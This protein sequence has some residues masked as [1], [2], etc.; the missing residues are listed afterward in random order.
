MVC[1]QITLRICFSQQLKTFLGFRLSQNFANIIRIIGCIEFIW[2]P[3]LTTNTFATTNSSRKIAKST[4]EW[5]FLSDFCEFSRFLYLYISKRV[6]TA[7]GGGPLKLPYGISSPN[8]NPIKKCTIIA[9]S[10]I[11]GQVIS[12]T[13]SS[14][15]LVF[16]TTSQRL[17]Y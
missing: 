6:I 9:V 7:I 10:E 12:K 1:L 3:I 2:S 16:G 13:I 4:L 11:I 15:A 8:Y 5:H 17:S 14:I